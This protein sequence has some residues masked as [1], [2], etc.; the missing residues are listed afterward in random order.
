MTAKATLVTPATVLL[1]LG[2]GTALSLMGDATLYVVLPTHTADAG[3]GVGAVGIIL[4][5]NRAIRLLTNG[6]AGMLYDRL[7]RRRLFVASLFL[8]ALSTALYAATNGFGPLFLA[9]LLW[10]ISWS[11]I[12]VGG[13]T[14]ILDAT[15]ADDRGRWTGLYQTWF[16][17]GSTLGSLA[18]G[19]L[20]DAVGYAWTMW[21]CAAIT[22]GGG[23]F[24]LA[25]LPETRARRAQTA[26][27]QSHAAP[28]GRL[29]HNPAIWATAILQGL[30]RFV[31]A[32]VLAA[33]L[34]LLVQQASLPAWLGVASVTGILLAA[35]SILSMVASPFCGALSDRA[36]S[37]WGVMFWAMAAGAL[38]FAL[39]A[40]DGLLV[41]L[42]GL[43]LSAV[44]SGGVQALTTALTGD[45]AP[46]QQRG[47]A[48]GLLHT[49]GDLGS[50]LG[51]PVAY[52]LIPFL[53]L[54]GVYGACGALLACGAALT[55]PRW[56]AGRKP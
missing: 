22:A 49:T 32:G 54:G 44:F 11:G 43:I 51:P 4:G 19:L 46:P 47:R 38:G 40:F 7:P 18:G 1:P 39:L 41:I 53:S 2:L 33:T 34:G 21:I 37:R 36:G 31:S 5:V 24:A 16:F 10:G 29:R 28:P 55:V 45:L 50:A 9:R 25:R 14:I 17:L 26:E 8:G 12:W 52:A 35:R 3:I 30:N 13:A 20:T 6:P 15:G 48:I 23:L 56:R 27:A 42:A